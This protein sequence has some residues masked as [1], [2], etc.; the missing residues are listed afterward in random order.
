MYIKLQNVGAIKEATVDLTGLS[1][2]AGK[3]GT[4]K[5]TIGKTVY[6]VIKSVQEQDAICAKKHKEFIDWACK[7][8]YFQLQGIIARAANTGKQI[9]SDNELL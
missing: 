8:V 3:N 6:T 2:I 4:G 9:A 5:S 7:N 1:V